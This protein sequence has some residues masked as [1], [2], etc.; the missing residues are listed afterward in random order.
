ML[1]YQSLNKLELST[2][3][4]ELQQKNGQEEYIFKIKRLRA[5]SGKA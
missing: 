4:S 3:A 1:I 2:F 5:F